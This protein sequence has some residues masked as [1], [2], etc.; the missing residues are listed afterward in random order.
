MLKDKEGKVQYVVGIGIDITEHREADEK[1]RLYHRIFLASNEG[2]TISDP[3]G[4]LIECNPAL[5]K[6]IGESYGKLIGK[7]SAL[8]LAQND[9]QKIDQSLRNTN[10]FRGEVEGNTPFGLKYYIDLSI[11]PVHDDEG[12]LDCYV[13]MARDITQQKKDQEALR[14]SEERFR[15]L[16]ENSNNIIYSLNP[17]GI[18]TYLSPKYE[19]FT[20]I[21]ANKNIGKNIKNILYEDDEE[22]FL[23]WLKSGIQMGEEKRQNLT[24]RLL[25]KNSQYRWFVSNS[26]V[27]RDE[28]G[29]I[30]E[31]IGVAQDITELKDLLDELE[32]AN[33]SL[34]DTHAQLVQSE[35][36][37]SLGQLVA[38]I[39][40]EINTPIGSVISIHN[41]LVRAVEKLK[42]ILKDDFNKN[43]PNY[44]K[45]VQIL[46]LIEEANRVIQDGSNRVKTIVSRLRSFARLDEAELVESDIHIG[47][48]D[49]LMLIH[50]EIKHNIKVIKNF[51]KIPQISCFMARL[52]QVFL[53]ILINAK[54]SITN[55]GEITITTYQKINNIYIEFKDSGSGIRK[56]DLNKIFDPG[57]TTKGVGIGTG[58]GLSICY[59]IIKDH[60]GEIQVESEIGKGSLFRIIIPTNLEKILE[61][62]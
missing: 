20:G 17:E 16:V 23:N 2:I 44:N 19:E 37:A 32:E 15:K 4:K 45:V 7:H 38:G 50:H 54:Q 49:T 1:L 26:S 60:H 39:A 13:G 42:N 61:I 59:Q 40:H 62:S 51:G 9:S 30:S 31:I 41:T 5:Q 8:N 11:F 25:D 22:M 21:S 53:N 55:K 6:S 34:R 52:N 28:S 24:G 33:R 12:N 18:I 43:S 3:E 57:F 10:S 46:A 14:A 35:K 36:M 56:E 47:L 48:E 27:I 58:L 29:N